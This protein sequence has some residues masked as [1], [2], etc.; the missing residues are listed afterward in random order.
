MPWLFQHLQEQCHST[1]PQTP[2]RAQEPLLQGEV[3]GPQAPL[4]V[5]KF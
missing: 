2:R 5:S 1:P 4:Q 3:P